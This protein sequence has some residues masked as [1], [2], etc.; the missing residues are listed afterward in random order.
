MRA[1]PLRVLIVDD[2]ADLVATMA[3]RLALRGIDVE[4]ATNGADAL[5]HVNAGDFNVVIL[6]VKMPGIDGLEMMAH[7]QRKRPGL[8]VILF[9]GHTSL[10]DAEQGMQEGAFAYLLKPIDIDDM[11]EKIEGA[12]AREKEPEP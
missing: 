8:P 9:T 1:D 5:S 10:P 2:E 11:I 4:T 12:A 7:V 6:D 3:E